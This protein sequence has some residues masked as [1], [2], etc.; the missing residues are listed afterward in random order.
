[1]IKAIGTGILPK[2]ATAVLVLV[3]FFNT[4][5]P[6]IMFTGIQ[7]RIKSQM[8]ES[9][10]KHIDES[11][12]THIILP[13]RDNSNILKDT[14]NNQGEFNYRDALYDIIKI[15]EHG[16]WFEIFAIED[17]EE[18]ELIKNYISADTNSTYSKLLHLIKFFELEFLIKY[19]CI[20]LFA[21]ISRIC[22]INHT[23]NLIRFYIK[24]LAP[25]P[26]IISI[27]S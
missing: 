2:L 15:E 8:K 22:T 19:S 21:G 11:L 24:V 12:I 6:P 14:L 16:L 7:S 25:P 17:E 23:G 18:E 27:F 4:T 9:I 10:K 3:L 20:G 5:A 13:C 1:M 26:R